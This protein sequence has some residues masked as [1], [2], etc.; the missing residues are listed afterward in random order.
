MSSFS[1]SC[2]SDAHILQE[3][4]AAVHGKQ[5]NSSREEATPDEVQVTPLRA[6]LE[7][8]GKDYSSLV[9]FASTIYDALGI[10]ALHEF[11]CITESDVQQ[12]TL[13]AMQK[14]ALLHLARAH[15]VG[16]KTFS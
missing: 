12:V 9:P 11:A 1:R 16:T 10:A 8:A 5:T 15:N 13:P 3:I 6:V 14:R 2:D 7:S 4:L